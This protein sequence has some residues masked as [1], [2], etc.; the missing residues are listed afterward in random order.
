MIAQESKYLWIFSVVFLFYHEKFVVYT[1]KNSL[2]E[3]ILIKT[4]N[5]LFLYRR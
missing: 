4:L 1:H 3:A 5:I 2:I